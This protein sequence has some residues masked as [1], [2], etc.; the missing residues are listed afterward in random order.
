[1]AAPGSSGRAALRSAAALLPRGALPPQRPG[2][3]ARLTRWWVCRT[4]SLSSVLAAAATAAAAGS[5]MLPAAGG[6]C[7]RQA[8]VLGAGGGRNNKAASRQLQSGSH[9]GKR[10]LW[11][12][13]G[14]APR[15]PGHPR[16]RQG[17][18]S[19]RRQ[20]CPTRPIYPA[21]HP[22][23]PHPAPQLNT[24]SIVFITGLSKVQARSRRGQ[25]L[26][27]RAQG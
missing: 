25:G 5:A 7:A 21:Q 12:G 18:G 19:G 24:A 15:R 26:R 8:G 27:A 1:M 11:G 2:A 14:R 17:H 22:S 6:C 23:S 16:R 10:P 13:A 4:R 9:A 3:G 20:C